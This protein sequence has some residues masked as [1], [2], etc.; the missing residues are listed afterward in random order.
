MNTNLLSGALKRVFG[1]GSVNNI[2]SSSLVPYCNVSGVPDGLS[3]ISNL[4]SALGV[5][6]NA[7]PYNGWTNNVDANNLSWGI[8]Y[9]GEGCIN[10]PEE[11]CYL[12][13]F[14]DTSED[15][16]QIAIG[17]STNSLY[18]RINTTNNAWKKVQ[19]ME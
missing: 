17:R 9:T 4:A 8:V 6:A 1:N 15:F 14:G 10:V 7:F 12:L 3:S 18:Y 11:Y 16:A 19:V 5:I 13:T 2:A